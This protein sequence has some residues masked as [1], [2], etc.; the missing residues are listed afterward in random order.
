MTSNPSVAVL[1]AAFN[2]IKW[3][4]EQIES[5]LNQKDVNLDIYISIDLSNDGTYEWCEELAIKNSNVNI[6]PY[7]NHFGSAGK[8]FFRLIKDVDFNHYNYISLADQD[9]IW[10]SDKVSKSIQLI[11]EKKLDGYSSN[12]IAFW[13]DGKKKI[14]DKSYSQKEYDYYFESAGPGCTFV[15]KSKPLKKFKNFLIENWHEVNEV[16]LHDWMIY[17]FF[18]ELSMVWY[19]DNNPSLYYRQHKNNQIGA[20]LN[21]RSYLNRFKKI[22][23]KWYRNE[24]QKI[25][26]LL[27]PYSKNKMC[28]DYFFL[29]LNFNKL[30]RRKRDRIILFFMNLIRIF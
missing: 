24:V 26:N 4:E 18:R 5:I 12:V 28:L 22:K 2:G 21:W 3:I 9:D 19:I 17:A 1:L 7:G 10:L 30:R 16:E 20:N 6:L 29:L 13:K 25:I 8:N 27:K 11:E 14:V 15:F 23:N